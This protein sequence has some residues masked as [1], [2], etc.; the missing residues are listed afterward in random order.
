[1]DEILSTI[2]DKVTSYN[3]FNNFFPG[4]IV[5]YIIEKTTRMSIADGDLLQNLFVYYFVGMIV[6]RVGSLF[7]EKILKS[8][9][10]KNKTSNQK[11]P[12]LKFAPYDKYIEASNKEPFIKVLCETNN[13]YRTIIAVFIVSLVVKLYDLLLYDFIINLGNT[14]QNLMHI[15][16]YLFMIV[17]LYIVIENRLNT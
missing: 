17:F 4:I 7:I 13:M 14:A 16:I 2:I 10:V 1:M 8:L 3:L 5:C 11:E 15:S 6:S 12:F 9:K